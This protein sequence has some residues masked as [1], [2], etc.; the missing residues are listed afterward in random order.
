[1]HLCVRG[2]R[3]GKEEEGETVILLKTTVMLKKGVQDMCV[4]VCNMYV[5]VM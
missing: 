1:M 4:C 2:L 5:H 3:K